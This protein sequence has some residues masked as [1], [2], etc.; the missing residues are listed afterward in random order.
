MRSY[1]FFLGVS[2]SLIS[3]VL[4]GETDPTE[5]SK[6]QVFVEKIALGSSLP[7]TVAGKYLGIGPQNG[8]TLYYVTQTMVNGQVPSITVSSVQT[9]TKTLMGA[10]ETFTLQKALNLVLF[11]VWGL[12]VLPFIQDGK[13]HQR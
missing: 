8:S 7:A 9:P 4:A 5:K 3:L 2:V 6:A 1:L 11:V 13:I 12:V 10:T